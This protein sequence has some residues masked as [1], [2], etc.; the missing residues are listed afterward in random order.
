MKCKYCDG[1]GV[2]NELCK[3]HF[4]EYFESKVYGCIDKYNLVPE[5]SKILV[6]VSGGKDSITILYLLN[7]RYK[8]VTAYT[9]DEGISGYRDK[10]LEDAKTFCQRYNI[11]MIIESVEDNFGF[12]LDEAV[13][14]TRKKPCNICGIMR[15]YLLN[16][17]KE[18]DIL[19]TG[20]NMD[21]EIQS[22][23]MNIMKNQIEL[24][25]R[26][27]PKPGI[28]NSDN[29][30]PR[31][32]PL[33]FCSEKEVM[34]YSYLMG[35]KMSFIEC[36]FAKLSFRAEIRDTINGYENKLLHR[37]ASKIKRGLL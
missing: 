6:G 3:G 23:L 5:G 29:F 13:P 4:I 20:H 10:T 11:P 25:A 16:K 2:L 34:T 26:L 32:K 15:R 19:A 21:D 27:G 9:V 36:P 35:F 22:I 28:I 31:V 33:Y 14:N 8:N 1:K 24:L 37:Y 17:H 7:K 18:Y 12:R 30:L